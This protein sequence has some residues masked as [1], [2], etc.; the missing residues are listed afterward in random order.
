M[1]AIKDRDSPSPLAIGD[2]GERCTMT[3]KA[4]DEALGLLRCVHILLVDSTY[5]SCL[6]ILC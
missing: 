3:G 5:L 2:R 1:Q 6:D 4:L